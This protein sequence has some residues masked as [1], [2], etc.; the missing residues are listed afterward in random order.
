MQ[1]YYYSIFFAYGSFLSAHFKGNYTVADLLKPT[2]NQTT[3]KMNNRSGE[4]IKNEMLRLKGLGVID[5]ESYLLSINNIQNQ[6]MLEPA[7]T[8]E[9]HLNYI[10]RIPF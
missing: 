7:R 8:G 6:E 2:K 4:K 3:N 10:D 9:T 1:M 5:T